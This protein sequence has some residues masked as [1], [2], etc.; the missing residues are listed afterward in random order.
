M[1]RALGDLAGGILSLD[2][3]IQE[4]SEA[5]EYDLISMGL[6]LRQLGTAELTWRDLKVIIQHGPAQSAL[7]RA[8]YPD[9][10]WGLSEQL[11]A[12]LLD[13]ANWLV[14]AKTKDGQSGRNRPKPIPRPGVEDTE[15]LGNTVMSIT[16]MDSFLGYSMRG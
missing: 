13:K 7:A 4:H 15:K 3:L 16:E 10:G 8:M 9:H 11:Q 12:A 2:V 6:R 1:E 14:W 5:I